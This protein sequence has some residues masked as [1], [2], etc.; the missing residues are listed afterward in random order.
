MTLNFH[1][2]AKLSGW[3][4]QSQPQTSPTPARAAAKSTARTVR[5]STA[6]TD[7]AHARCHG[8]KAAYWPLRRS[9]GA[10]PLVTPPT[11]RAGGSPGR[12]RPRFSPIA[13]A[14]MLCVVGGEPPRSVSEAQPV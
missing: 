1:D 11:L 13:L 9:C 12:A 3:E 8:G 6:C 5:A 4:C 14:D 7:P 2:P 10:P